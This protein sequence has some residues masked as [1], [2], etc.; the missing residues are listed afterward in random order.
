MGSKPTN[1]VKFFF[2][3]LGVILI[4][5]ECFLLED[6]FK[7]VPTPIEWLTLFAVGFYIGG[8]GVL[9]YYESKEP[10]VMEFFDHGTESNGCVWDFLKI[11]FWPIFL[12]LLSLEL[13][14]D[15]D[16]AQSTDPP[17]VTPIP[18]YGR[19]SRF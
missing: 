13:S 18:I 11:A 19:E 12:Y 8:S 9:L 6:Y 17:Y 10:G 3:C 16:T 14:D 1:V 5:V 4:I 7:D 2:G 15:T